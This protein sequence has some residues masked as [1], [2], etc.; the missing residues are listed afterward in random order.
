[1]RTAD[2]DIRSVGQ[3]GA[4]AKDPVQADGIIAIRTAAADAGDTAAAAASTDFDEPGRHGYDDDDEDYVH[5]GPRAFATAAIYKAALLAG[6]SGGGGREDADTTRGATAVA[7]TQSQPSG[8]SSGEAV[9]IAVDG[10]GR[11]FQVGANAESDDTAGKEKRAAQASS[12][13]LDGGDS[14]GAVDASGGARF[15]DFFAGIEAAFASDDDDDGDA[16]GNAASGTGVPADGSLPYHSYSAGELA[17][18]VPYRTTAVD[19]EYS[20]YQEGELLYEPYM[21]Y[22]SEEGGQLVKVV[23]VNGEGETWLPAEAAAAAAVTSG[24]R[25]RALLGGDDVLMAGPGP[26]GPAEGSSDGSAEQR[27]RERAAELQY[28]LYDVLGDE[29]V[30]EDLVMDEQPGS[31]EPVIV[32]E[33]DADESYPRPYQTKTLEAFEYVYDDDPDGAAAAVASV[34][35]AAVAAS[36]QSE[37]AAKVSDVAA[38]DAAD[39]D[40][41]KTTSLRLWQALYDMF[42]GETGDD[43]SFG[44]QQQA[45]YIR[46]YEKDPE[47]FWAVHDE[48]VERWLSARSATATDQ[49]AAAAAAAEGVPAGTVQVGALDVAVSVEQREDD[50]DAARSGYKYD[51]DDDSYSYVSEYERLTLLRGQ[52]SRLVQDETGF[53]P[54]D[55]SWV[56]RIPDDEAGV[57]EDYFGVVHD[58]Y[59]LPSYDAVYGSYEYA[60][61]DDAEAGYE[62]VR[63]ALEEVW[64][65]PYNF[66]QYEYGSEGETVQ[67]REPTYVDGGRYSDAV[68]KAVDAAAAAAAAAAADTAGMAE[69]GWVAGGA[70]T[71]ALW[72]GVSN[73][74]Y[75]YDEYDEY[76]EYEGVEYSYYDDGYTDYIMYAKYD[77]Y[78]D[79]DDYEYY[80]VPGAARAD[81]GADGDAGVQSGR[82]AGGQQPGT[83]AS[84]LGLGEMGGGGGGGTVAAV[85]F[86]T[87]STTSTIGAMGE[88]LHTTTST[89]TAAT[90]TTATQAAVTATTTTAATTTTTTATTTAAATDSGALVVKSALS[91]VGPAV[92]SAAAE[93]AAAAAALTGVAAA[94]AANQLTSDA[95]APVRDAGET[96]ATTTTT[97]TTTV[98]A[99]T[100]TA[101]PDSGPGLTVAA[102]RLAYLQAVTHWR[103]GGGGGGGGSGGAARPAGPA[104]AAGTSGVGDG[105]AEAL[106]A[107]AAA[108]HTALLLARITAA[109]HANAL[110]DLPVPSSGARNAAAAITAA[111]ADTSHAITA[112][113]HTA[114]ALPSPTTTSGAA[115]PSNAVL[116]TFGGGALACLTLAAALAAF[117]VVFYRRG[118]AYNLAGL[119]FGCR[120]SRRGDGLRS[121]LLPTDGGGSGAGRGLTGISRWVI[122][123]LGLGQRKR[124]GSGDDSNSS[125]GGAR[126]SG[127]GSGRARKS[128]A[129]S[130]KVRRYIDTRPRDSDHSE[131]DCQRSI[132]GGDEAAA[133]KLAA[134][135]APPPP[136]PPPAYGAG[137]AAQLPF[138]QIQPHCTAAAGGAVFDLQCNS[139]RS[140]VSS[141]EHTSLAPLAHWRDNGH[142]LPQ[143]RGWEPN[144]AAGSAGPAGSM[145]DASFGS[146]SHTAVCAAVNGIHVNFNREGFAA[147][148]DGRSVSLPAGVVDAP[149]SPVAAAPTIAAA[150]PDGGG[151]VSWLSIAGAPTAAGAAGLRQMAP[152]SAPAVQRPAPII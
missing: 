12:A 3:F 105:A 72:S 21:L 53:M 110:G 20:E 8:A 39:D 29:S 60:L 82:S 28:I 50:R 15:E 87:T 61:Y 150:V 96:A 44:P 115:A 69:D 152:P 74:I 130:T 36:A 63:E 6:R 49:A 14:A 137:A 122:D 41:D 26:K 117:A 19:P 89:V 123:G 1:M 125:D 65:Y 66:Q 136:P 103:A 120:A 104:G 51:Y 5:V 73:V 70:G 100:D 85:V 58:V 143:H 55:G 142:Q 94:T 91:S 126:G 83:A 30:F 56:K 71:D 52:G 127:S 2:L 132:S 23:P 81:V 57:V 146:L 68:A 80:E 27:V 133:M 18:D 17:E 99:L 40:I 34:P 45:M 42:G 113:T 16:F 124:R 86:H 106:L 114:A 93:A 118:L 97:T 78:D 145:Y 144:S 102:S 24:V 37:L 54:G 77:D 108:S 38:D 59:G 112:T 67:P 84:A 121:P 116:Q 32:Y 35:A 140:W 92:H 48:V 147:T 107:Q 148:D 90:T 46:L 10:D 138:L 79:Y 119:R 31:T 141:P 109:L 134:A 9:I 43:P 13:G 135:A 128:S 75:E 98:T 4:Q 151:A 62:E 22:D 33:Y 149:Y 25:A 139:P 111:H 76:D 129:T 7:A 101:R 47:R 131:G 95:A 11:R 64:G 88:Q